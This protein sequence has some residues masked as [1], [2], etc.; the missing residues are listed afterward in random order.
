MPPFKENTTGLWSLN[1]S[2]CSM[3]KI[4]SHGNITCF[5]LAV[6]GCLA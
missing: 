5:D 3:H 6:L 4:F 1:I 2:L